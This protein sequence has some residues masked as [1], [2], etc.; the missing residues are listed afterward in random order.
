MEYPAHE[1]LRDAVTTYHEKY[2]HPKH[3]F[4]RVVIEFDELVSEKKK[5]QEMLD[6]ADEQLK[7]VIGTFAEWQDF[8]LTKLNNQGE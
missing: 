8:R 7:L 1:A 3:I 2:T 4:W 5:M 6:Y